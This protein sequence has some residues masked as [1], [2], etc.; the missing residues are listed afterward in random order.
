MSIASVLNELLSVKSEIISALREK[1][2]SIKDSDGLKK[3]PDEIRELGTG[4]TSNDWFITRENYKLYF[5]A[6]QTTLYNFRSIITANVTLE[7][8][9]DMYFYYNQSLLMI[10]LPN[11]KKSI[12]TTKHMCTGCSKLQFVI[13]GSKENP[14]DGSYGVLSDNTLSS[15]YADKV[16][17]LLYLDSSSDMFEELVQDYYDNFAG[18]S[19]SADYFYA[20]KDG[21]NYIYKMYNGI[22][23]EWEDI[24]EDEVFEG[25]DYENLPM[26]LGIDEEE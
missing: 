3:V 2:S 15:F 16:S 9:P 10:N 19:R 23:D 14:F 4:Q 18:Y 11:F 25:Y 26:T 5:D 8:I 1:G 17:I 12:N 22:T 6:S 21:N 13:F 7:N 20:F 24:G